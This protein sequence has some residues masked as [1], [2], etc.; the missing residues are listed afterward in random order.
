MIK[1]WPKPGIFLRPFI[2]KESVTLR[3]EGEHSVGMNFMYLL[4]L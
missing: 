2:L 4:I 3:W 1:G